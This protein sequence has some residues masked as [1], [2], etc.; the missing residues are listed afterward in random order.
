[1][2]TFCVLKLL[3]KKQVDKKRFSANTPKGIMV[4]HLDLKDKSPIV[5]LR[6]ECQQKSQV[7]YAVLHL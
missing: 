6:T 2:K 7:F 3:F 5:D 1:M 4:V